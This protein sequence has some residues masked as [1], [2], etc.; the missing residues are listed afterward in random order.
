MWDIFISHA[1]ED[2]ET[3]AR[4]LAEMLTQAGLSVW[5][6]EFT[7]TLGDSLRRSIDNGLAQ[8]RY[9][10][11]IL[12]HSFF[13]KEWP[14]RELDGLAAREINSRKVIL[15]VWHGVNRY[16]I[17]SYSPMLAD[18]LAISTSRGLTVVLEE[19]L[20]VTGSRVSTTEDIAVAATK[21]VGNELIANSQREPLRQ[22]VEI[23][24]NQAEQEN[25]PTKNEGRWKIIAAAAIVVALLVL[26]FVFSGSFR[27]SSNPDR[28]HDEVVRQ[29]RAT[30][31]D[32]IRRS[33]VQISISGSTVILNGTL[34]SDADKEAAAKL[35]RSVSGVETVVNN[36]VVSPSVPSPTPID[37]SAQG[38]RPQLPTQ[39]AK[40]V[41]VLTL[42][43]NEVSKT[44]GVWLDAV[45]DNGKNIDLI[46]F[47]LSPNA[48]ADLMVN[49]R[50]TGAFQSVEIKETRQDKDIKELQ[51][52]KFEL[53]CSKV[54]NVTYTHV[55]ELIDL[56]KAEHEKQKKK[57]RD[58]AEQ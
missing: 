14:Q 25:K 46:G 3:V 47:A 11:V 23:V 9:G 4:P 18:R 36:I 48:V 30:S 24:T 28:L 45:S 17:V 13:S 15:P 33:D 20:R 43:S 52:F 32:S 37:H 7:L 22:A 44:D 21:S 58:G 27:Q 8:S 1:W 10:I 49:L 55:Q 34:H 56:G 26:Y 51:A 5:Y 54:P 57:S 39:E 29:F 53:L 6:D 41:D 42:I 16:D 31:L 12:S 40:P 38:A 19:I 2:K 50:R 35:A